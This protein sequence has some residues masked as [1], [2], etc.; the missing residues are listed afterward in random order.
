[1][2]WVERNVF[3]RFFIFVVLEYFFL[4]TIGASLLNILEQF[5]EQPDLGSFARLLGESIPKYWIFFS[6]YILL[7]AL[8]C[9]PLFLL[10]PIGLIKAIFRFGK[11]HLMAIDESWYFN[12]GVEYPSYLLIFVVG[13][14]YSCIAPVVIFF[15]ALFFAVGFMFVKHQV[16]YVSFP[17]YESGGECWPMVFSRMVR[18]AS[19]KVP[20]LLLRLPQMCTSDIQLCF[21]RHIVFSVLPQNKSIKTSYR[22]QGLYAPKSPSWACLH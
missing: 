21:K 4:N 11:S 2:S 5:I 17:R 3:H 15:S 13:V 6:S 20:A 19:H 14:C 22:S 7:N 18:I 8:V 10:N 9:F 1:M 16:L 12:Y